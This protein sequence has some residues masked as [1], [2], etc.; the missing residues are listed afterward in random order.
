MQSLERF[1]SNE[2]VTDPAVV[3]AHYAGEHAD[4]FLLVALGNRTLECHTHQSVGVPQ[5][6]AAE[7]KPGAADVDDV[8]RL[9]RAT[10][11]VESNESGEADT[12]SS[13]AVAAD[14]D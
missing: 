14:G 5:L 8:V 10:G 3:D 7:V 6:F 4:G 2:L 9:R 11:E 1:R 12:L 13:T